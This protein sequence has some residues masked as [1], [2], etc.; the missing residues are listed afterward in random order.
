MPL[1]EAAYKEQIIDEVGDDTAG[2][3]ASRITRLWTKHDN[4]P[5]LEHQY[6]YAKRSAIDVMLARVRGQT[7][8][9]DGDGASVDLNKLFDHLQAMRS[10][11]TDLITEA[12]SGTSSGGAVGDLTT[13]AP[14]APP[15]TSFVDANDR[16]YRGDPYY[17][18]KRRL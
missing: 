3:L 16:A 2:T 7:T 1:D 14:I 4:Q 10:F 11:V 18:R 12:E 6:L 15:S 5:T 13:T 9:R 8:I 17:S